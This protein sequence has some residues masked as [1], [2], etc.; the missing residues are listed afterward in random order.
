VEELTAALDRLRQDLE[1]H[2]GEGKDTEQLRVA[3]RG[4]GA[5][6]DRILTR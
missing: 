4:Y 1:A 2:Q 5:F 6:I 3:L